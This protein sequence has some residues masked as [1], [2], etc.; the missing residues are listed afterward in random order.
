MSRARLLLHVAA[1]LLPLA[2]AATFALM[3]SRDPDFVLRMTAYFGGAG[4]LAA[5]IAVLLRWRAFD[6]RARAG[7]GGWIAGIGMAAIAHAMFGV[8]LVIGLAIAL[9]GWRQSAGTGSPFDLV[10]QALFFITMSV[11]PLGILT[12]PV[13]AALAEFIAR[14][15]HRELTD[16]VV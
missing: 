13:T 4:A 7:R 12:F 9:G 14:M 8:L 6:R 15:R 2:A 1:L 10:L 5:Q 16:V 11:L 3:V